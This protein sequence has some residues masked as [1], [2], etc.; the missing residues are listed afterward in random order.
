MRSSR[1][2]VTGRWRSLPRRLPRPR[3]RERRRG[4]HFRVPYGATCD[5]GHDLACHA[6]PE[7]G[8]RKVIEDWATPVHWKLLG[9]PGDT[10]RFPLSCPG[11]C[12]PGLL[13]AVAAGGQGVGVVEA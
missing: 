3:A 10:R 7:V 5:A 4:Q 12:P 2:P 8:L 1:V 9:T 6:Q 11:R 13:R